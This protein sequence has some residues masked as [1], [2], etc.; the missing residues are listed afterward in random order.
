MRFGIMGAPARAH[1]AR[2]LSH[3]LFRRLGDARGTSI[4]EA[5]VITP[6]LLL[7]TLSIVDFGLLF[8]VHLSLENGVSQATRFAVTGNQMAD[9]SNPATLLN[10][11]DSI[12]LAMRQATPTLTIP[13]SAFTFTF[14]PTAG[15]AWQSGTGGPGDIGKVTINYTWK[16]F[17]PMLWPFFTNGQINLK[18]DS[19]MKNEAK[20]Q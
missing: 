20:A 17:N 4:V 16:F 1:M 3:R 15:G 10:R 9:P 18:A 2:N 8:F 5:A 7:L 19:I 11:T 12:K 14:M 6:L 13:D